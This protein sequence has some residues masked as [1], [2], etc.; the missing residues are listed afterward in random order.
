[1][2]IL[3]D[4]FLHDISIFTENIFNLLVRNISEI[5]GIFL[6]ITNSEEKRIF[7]LF[8]IIILWKKIKKRKGNY[9]IK[10]EK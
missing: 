3:E 7:L 9:K 2:F 4:I 5:K 6:K 10:K 1:M 8:R